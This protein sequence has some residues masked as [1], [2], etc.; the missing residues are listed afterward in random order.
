M[1]KTSRKS[2]IHCIMYAAFDEILWQ[3]E[4]A[5]DFQVIFAQDIVERI[6]E[7]QTE[8]HADNG[9]HQRNDSENH[10]G[11]A[12]VFKALLAAAK[13]MMWTIKPTNGI[14]MTRSIRM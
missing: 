6:H 9:K 12:I 1:Q 3:S 4:E 7:N 8:D 2:G 10:N 13:Q 5:F 11:T 14:F